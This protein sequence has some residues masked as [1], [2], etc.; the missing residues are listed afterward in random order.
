M[1]LIQ[2]ATD[3]VYSGKKG[4]YLESDLHDPTDVYGKTKSLGEFSSDH[5]SWCAVQLLGGK[6]LTSTA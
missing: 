2:I 5:I 3:C 1:H 6:K 4:D